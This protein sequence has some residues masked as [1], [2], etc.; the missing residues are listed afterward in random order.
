MLGYSDSNKDGY[1]RPIIYSTKPKRLLPKYH[2]NITLIF[3]FAMVAA[4]VPD[5]VVVF[6]K[7]F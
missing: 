2:N 3:V 1:C 4:A 7:L 6:T 5:A